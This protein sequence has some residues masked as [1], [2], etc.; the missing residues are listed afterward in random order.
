M[1]APCR[2]SS[3]RSLSRRIRSAI[4]YIRSLVSWTSAANASRS[5]FWARSTR[6]RTVTPSVP[7]HGD[8]VTTYEWS[9][10]PN[11]HAPSRIDA[12]RPLTPRLR[13]RAPATCARH[14]RDGGNLTNDSA[15]HRDHPRGGGVL[16]GVLDHRPSRHRRHPTGRWRP[17]S[18]SSWRSSGRG[19]SGCTWSGASG[20]SARTRSTRKSRTSWP[21]SRTHRPP[22]LGSR[23]RHV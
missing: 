5:P 4:A 9:G 16:P 13:P 11:V 20:R 8:A 17:S 18:G 15:D 6:S 21:S 2:A 19:S 7:R 3:A 10:G 12:P 23:A 14:P 1:R 22:I